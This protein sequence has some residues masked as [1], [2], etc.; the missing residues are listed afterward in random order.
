V[1]ITVTWSIGVMWC[2]LVWAGFAMN[3]RAADVK[4]VG[5][6]QPER[7]AVYY[8]DVEKSEAFLPYDVIVFDA[9]KHP[10]LRELQNR[11]KSLLGYLSVF[12]AAPYREHYE[13]L[14]SAGLLIQPDGKKGREYIDIR[15]REWSAM[16]VDVIIPELIKEGFDGVMLDTLDDA[17]ALEERQPKSYA[18]MSQA[19]VQTIGTIR[20]HYPYL[21]IMVNRAFGILPHVQMKVDMVLAESTMSDARDKEKAP[22]MFDDASRAH[23]LA[24]LKEAKQSVPELKIYTLDYWD[25]KDKAGVAKIY[26]QQRALGYVPYVA[27]PDL[28]LFYPEQDTSK[29]QGAKP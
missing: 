1:N 21:K 22:V 15:K 28:Q 12:E 13:E 25:M 8:T 19:A 14:K 2:L 9:D 16:L 18:G 27:T 5:G 24:V 10:P 20:M 7:L 4:T 29:K 3:A 23:V 11:G 6:D 26:A 17:L